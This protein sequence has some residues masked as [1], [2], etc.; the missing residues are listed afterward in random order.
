V[1]AEFDTGKPREIGNSI[2]QQHTQ[3]NQHNSEH[4]RGRRRRFEFIAQRVVQGDW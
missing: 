1:L 4:A 2:R 3:D